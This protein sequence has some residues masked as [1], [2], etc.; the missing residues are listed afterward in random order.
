MMPKPILNQKSCSYRNTSGTAE[1]RFIVCGAK[2]SLI[3]TVAEDA[4]LACDVYE[5]RATRRRGWRRRGIVEVLSWLLHRRRLEILRLVGLLSIWDVVLLLVVVGFLMWRLESRS[6]L[7][8]SLGPSGLGRFGRRRHP[9]ALSLAPAINLR[10]AIVKLDLLPV[11]SV[12]LPVSDSRDLF[13]TAPNVFDF[14]VFVRH[15]VRDF[16]DGDRSCGGAGGHL[17][18]L[19][20][21]VVIFDGSSR[22]RGLRRP[23]RCSRTATGATGATRTTGGGIGVA[24]IAPAR[25]TRHRGLRMT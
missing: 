18:D 16:L 10:D 17:H 15:L 2:A 22:D 6:L 5:T 24:V 4:F 11:V 8:E 21:P 12:V 23:P 13:L 9:A 3:P 20:G 1:A 19:D 7:Y 14:V 25:T